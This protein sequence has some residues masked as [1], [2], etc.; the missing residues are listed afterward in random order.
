MRFSQQRASFSVASSALAITALLT[1]SCAG[2]SSVSPQ[3][4]AAAPAPSNSTDQYSTYSI[5]PAGGTYQ[6]NLPA[7][8]SGAITIGPNAAPAGTTMQVGVGALTP[9]VGP[10]PLVT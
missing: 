4:P 6:L 8:Y 2:G 1:V 3:I 10:Q 7:G 5:S 9:P